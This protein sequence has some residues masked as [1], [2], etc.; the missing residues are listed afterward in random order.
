MKHA[1]QQWN[2]DYGANACVHCSE[3]V[4]ISEDTAK[5]AVTL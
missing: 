3:V 4:P 5:I 2:L 1:I